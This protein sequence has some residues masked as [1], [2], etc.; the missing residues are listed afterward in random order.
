VV[1]YNGKSRR[2]RPRLLPHAGGASFCFQDKRERT[3]LVHSSSVFRQTTRAVSTT[4]ELP[5]AIIFLLRRNADGGINPRRRLLRA[6]WQSLRR[7]RL[8]VQAWVHG[9][10]WG[11][12]LFFPPPEP[13]VHPVVIESS[14][15]GALSL[16][17]NISPGS[18]ITKMCGQ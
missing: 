15:D 8:R 7:V 10:Q 11:I 3:E 5:V 13:Q 2:S 18:T 9:R 17:C 6:Q 1:Q 16:S 4:S 14:A 12:C